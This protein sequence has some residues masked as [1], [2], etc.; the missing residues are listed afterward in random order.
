MNWPENMKTSYLLLGFALMTSIGFGQN[1][2]ELDVSI[3]I[4]HKLE[5]L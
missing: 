1:N 4:K 5:H 2:S 3:T